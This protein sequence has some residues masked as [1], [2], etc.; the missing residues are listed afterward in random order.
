MSG[1]LRARSLE[2]LPADAEP[3]DALERLRRGAGAALEAAIPEPE[4]GLAAGIV[5]GLR[6]QV[7]RD[8]A[9]DFTTV[10]ASHVVAIS[11]WNIAIV[12][13]SVAALGG[14][15]ARRRRALLTAI[16]IVLY[17]AFAGASASVV[18]AA[19]MAGVVLVARETG[20]AGRAAAALGW[21]AML[22]LLVDPH[23]VG[24]AGF[25]LS[26]LAT[27]GIL[28][29]ASPFGAWLTARDSWSPA[30]LADRMPCRVVGRPGRHA[31]GR[32]ASRSAVSRSSRPR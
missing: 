17:V 22:L 15:L 31:P 21:A 16:A 18:R 10:G 32:P 6:D 23:L 7:D 1:T 29:W 28:A 27:A 5:V 11:G 26:T 2:V 14:G 3:A 24:D 13:A 9:A 12:A 8:L 19:A 25:Q 4:A 20:R 30:G